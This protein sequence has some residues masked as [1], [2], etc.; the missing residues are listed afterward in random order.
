MHG[1]AR[2][3]FRTWAK[4]DVLGNNIK[5]DQEAVEKCLLHSTKDMYHGAYDR[6]EFIAERKLIME[7][8]GKF[9]TSKLTSLHEGNNNGKK[10]ET[11]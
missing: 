10:Q 7:E 4:D 6:A 8:W 2:A 11:P 3:G 5:F 9:C 1:T